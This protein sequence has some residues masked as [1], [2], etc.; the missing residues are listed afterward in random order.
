MPSFTAGQSRG[1]SRQHLRALWQTIGQLR[2]YKYLLACTVRRHVSQSPQYRV[3]VAATISWPF[4][5]IGPSLDV[6]N[7]SSA[8]RILCMDR[9]TDS[10][11]DL[12]IRMPTGLCESICCRWILSFLYWVRFLSC[13]RNLCSWSPIEE[14]RDINL[15]CIGMWWCWKYRQCA[16]FP[17]GL[18]IL[19]VDSH[20]LL[21]SSFS[22]S[23][24]LCWLSWSWP[25]WLDKIWGT[26]STLFDVILHASEWWNGNFAWWCLLYTRRAFRLVFEQVISSHA[27][28]H[29]FLTDRS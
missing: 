24:L 19:H 9:R 27:V 4:N 16:M 17:S 11:P 26:N 2:Q 13:S 28:N 22:A 20:R 18:N 8:E 25:F 15:L 6:G 21:S 14:N 29:W 7:I 1:I 23:E 10:T 3:Q 12:T 5:F